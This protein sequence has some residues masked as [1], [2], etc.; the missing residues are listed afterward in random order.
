MWL[1][2]AGCHVEVREPDAPCTCCKDRREVYSHETWDDW[3]PCPRCT[4]PL[5]R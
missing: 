2:R 1:N 4:Q 5:S 3:E